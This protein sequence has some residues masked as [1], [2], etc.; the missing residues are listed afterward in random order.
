MAFV[1]IKYKAEYRESKRQLLTFT[2]YKKWDEIANFI[3][4]L[5]LILKHKNVASEISQQV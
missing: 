2:V 1:N 4:F 3:Y 5:N